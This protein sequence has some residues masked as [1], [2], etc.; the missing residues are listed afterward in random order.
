MTL[1][2][3]ERA[4]G[5]TRESVAA[6]LRA[7]ADGGELAVPL[8]GPVAPVSG[9]RRWSPGAGVTSRWRAWRKATS[10]PWRSWPRRTVRRCR[11]PCTGCGRRT[12]EGAARG[13]AGGPAGGRRPGPYGSAPG[14][15]SIPSSVAGFLVCDDVGWPVIGPGWAKRST[16]PGP[17]RVGAGRRWAKPRNRCRTRGRPLGTERMGFLGQLLSTWSNCSESVHSCS[18]LSG[19]SA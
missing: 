7:M 13:C 19:S 5:R 11:T 17:A 1:S 12:P 15:L 14:V 3:Y 10:T 4:A 16:C 9:G 2:A 18:A 8:P 6:G